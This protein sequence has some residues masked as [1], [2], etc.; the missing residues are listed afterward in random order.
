MNASFSAGVGQVQIKRGRD[1]RRN[2]SRNE[3]AAFKGQSRWRLLL[4]RAYVIII[5]I[6]T[7]TQTHIKRHVTKYDMMNNSHYVDEHRNGKS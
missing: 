3:R 6:Y 5:I 4:L 1:V 2:R 7:N